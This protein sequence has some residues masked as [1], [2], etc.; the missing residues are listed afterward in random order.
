MYR[1]NNMFIEDD[2][3]DEL[4]LV[5]NVREQ[6]LVVIS[7]CAHAGIINT[8]YAA[9]EITGIKK[10]LAVIGGFHLALA[11]NKYIDD[12]INEFLKINPKYV[13]PTHCTGFKAMKKFSEAMGD[14]FLFGC[15]GSSFLF[16]NE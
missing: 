8:I 9:Q 12:V 13:V 15:A 1:D 4:G 14:A 6:G 7:G 3:C 10:I 11:S 5:I 16:E 2:I